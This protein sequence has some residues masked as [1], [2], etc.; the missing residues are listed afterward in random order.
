MAT[1]FNKNNLLF[2]DF[3]PVRTPASPFPLLSPFFPPSSTTFRLL[4]QLQDIE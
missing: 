3:L 1:K 2:T 4:R